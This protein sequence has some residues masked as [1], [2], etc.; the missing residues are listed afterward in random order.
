MKKLSTSIAVPFIAAK[1][2]GSFE[3]VQVGAKEI[4]R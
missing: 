4:Y 1:A 3:A 2:A